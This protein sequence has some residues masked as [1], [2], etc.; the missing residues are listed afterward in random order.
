MVATAAMKLTYAI[1]DVH[2]RLDLLNALVPALLQDADASGCPTP[3]LIGLGDYVDRGPDSRGVVSALRQGFEGFSCT[4]LKGNHDDLLVKAWEGGDISMSRWFNQGGRQCLESYGWAPGEPADPH[5]WIPAEDVV[6]LASLPTSH[7][8][9]DYFFVHAGV[10]P[11]T[12]FSA[13]SEKDLLWIRRPFLDHTGDF[14]RVVVHG[15]TSSSEP[16]VHYNR[17]GLD[18]GAYGSGILSCACLSPGMEPRIIQ[19]V[20]PGFRFGSEN[21]VIVILGTGVAGPEE[22]CMAISPAL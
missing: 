14:G 11:L 10:N 17:I 22:A 2:G 18:T 3:K 1:G 5:L 15:H 19:A 16:Q 21:E 9:G 7:D 6:F 12:H 20:A 13:Q 8:D 4:W